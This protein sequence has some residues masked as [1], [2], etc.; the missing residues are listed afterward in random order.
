VF[1]VIL[2][3]KEISKLVKEKRMI[4][5]YIED[6]LQSVSYDLTASNIIQIFNKVQTTINLKSKDSI[7]LANKEVSINYGYKIMPN[8]YIL[9]K[10]KESFNLPDNLTGH[11][12]PR[13]TFTRLGLVLSV[14]HINPTFS[15]HLYLGMLNSTPNAIE[16]FPDLIIG[17][18]IFEQVF[19]EITPELLYKN[20]KSAKYQNESEFIS[21]DI[22][23]EIP[24]AL[25]SK[26]DELV[27]DLI[28]K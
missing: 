6:N 27:K 3:D 2:T 23:K 16:I 13:T 11:I 14:Q 4:E 21:P 20:K 24:P 8:E 9:I 25:K 7:A 15:G 18:V 12:R 19:G 22:T 5:N 10:T 28:G 1:I 17:Q 26:Y